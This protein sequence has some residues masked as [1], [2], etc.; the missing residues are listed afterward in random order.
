MR[1]LSGVAL[2]MLLVGAAHAP[3]Q[4]DRAGFRSVI[5]STAGL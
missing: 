2:L 4:T 5:R 3:R 1:R